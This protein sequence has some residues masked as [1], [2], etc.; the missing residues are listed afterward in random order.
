MPHAVQQ[1]ESCAWGSC[2]TLGTR[3]YNTQ[4]KAPTTS[5]GKDLIKPACKALRIRCRRPS[6]WHWCYSECLGTLHNKAAAMTR[7]HLLGPEALNPIHTCNLCTASC[8]AHNTMQTLVA[9]CPRC[10]GFAQHAWEGA[11]D[12]GSHQHTEML[13][14]HAIHTKARPC[15]SQCSR[16]ICGGCVANTRSAAHIQPPCP[17][18][19]GMQNIPTVCKQAIKQTN[20]H[21]HSSTCHAM[22]TETRDYGTITKQVSAAGVQNAHKPQQN[23]HRSLCVGTSNTHALQAVRALMVVHPAE[24]QSSA[25]M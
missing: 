25:V 13:Q 10:R 3:L 4:C 14:L 16:S 1:A 5:S 18:T 15:T 20:Q 7:R 21:C 17:N 24:C 19:A 23:L 12:A 22:I 8:N 6:H 11:R 2:A 9:P